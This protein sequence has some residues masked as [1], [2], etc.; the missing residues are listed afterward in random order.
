MTWLKKIGGIVKQIGV[1]AGL[2]APTASLIFPGSKEKIDVVSHDLA[3]LANIVVT[4]E[5]IGQ[6]A[7]LPGPEKLK[8]AAPLVANAIVQSALLAGKK[9]E[10]PELFAAGSQKIADGMADVLNS[11]KADVPITELV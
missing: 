7:G 10:N 11:L 9:I 8:M 6:T 4:V 1:Y 5:A 3:E 2:I